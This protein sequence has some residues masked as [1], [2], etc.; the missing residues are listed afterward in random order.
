MDDIIK[1]GESLEKSSLLNGGA[2]ETVRNEI[3]IKKIDFLR[4]DGPIGCFIDSTY[5]F[6]ID[7]TCNFFNDKCCNR[8]R[9]KRWISSFIPLMMKVLGKEVRRVGKEY[10]NMDK[11]F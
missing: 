10:N 2:T 4:N 3:K 9:T 11:R 5:D 8:K 7:T 1:I 6:Y